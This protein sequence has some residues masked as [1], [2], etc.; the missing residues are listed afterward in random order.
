MKLKPNKRLLNTKTI[1]YSSILV[2]AATIIAVWLFGLGKDR[3]MYENSLLST[4]ILFGMFFLFLAIGLF[5]GV[6]LKDNLGKFTDRIKKT[7]FPEMGDIG[8][9]DLP[10]DAGDGIGGIILGIILW[11]IV[12]ILAIFLLWFFGAVLWV[13]MLVF[14]AM[15]YWV[16][17]RALRLVFKHSK[18]CKG[19][20][21]KSLK[22]ALLYTSL[23]CLWIYGV[24]FLVHALGE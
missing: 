2:V 8:G 23:Y 13:G 6:K 4:S 19:D 21:S 1:F 17:F 16:F 3:T 5:R 18:M 12:S 15:L 24:I 22:I 20:L 7:K 9:A 10:L 14:M 11:I